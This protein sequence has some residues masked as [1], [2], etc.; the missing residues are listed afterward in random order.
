MTQAGTD[1]DRLDRNHRLPA[2]EARPVVKTELRQTEPRSVAYSRIHFASLD[3]VRGLAILLVIL[4]HFSSSLSVL[5]FANPALGLLRFGWCGVDVF[6]VLSGFLI[7]GV[8]LDTKASPDYF[9]NFYARRV[10]RIFPLYYGSLFVVFLLRLALPGAGV[11]GSH[12]G[13]L[14]PGSLLWPGLYLENFAIL[15]QGPSVTGVTTHYWSLAVEEHF[16]L[17]WP[18]MVWLATRQQIM[19]LAVAIAIFSIVVRAL[20]YRHGADLDAAF[21]L[22]PLRMDGLAIG[23]IASLAIRGRAGMDVIVRRAWIALISGG[24]LLVGLLALRH[25]IHQSDPALWIFAYPL[26]AIVTATGL[27]VGMGPNPVRR[28]LSLRP[29]CWFGKYS[30]GLYVWHPI[31]GMVLLHSQF[32]LVNQASGKPAILL[33]ALGALALDLLV[34]WLSY[35]LWEKHF[36]NLKRYFA[37]GAPKP[38][39]LAPSNNLENLPTGIGF[40]SAL[41]RQHP[42]AHA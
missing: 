27:L 14:S 5:G 6:F 41:K 17:I 33:A 28:F 30:F 20:L 2:V 3:G 16:Y 36:L 29:L 23:A 9:R 19:V 34:A 12:D 1:P 15:L 18:L 22:T 10:L 40:G 24:G 11:W 42:G 8:L 39:A 38:T 7:T 21:G 26:V 25:T 31:I 32:A 13:M 4:Y 35:N 37:S